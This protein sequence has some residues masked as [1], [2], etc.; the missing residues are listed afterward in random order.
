MKGFLKMDIVELKEAIIRKKAATA[1]I[2]KDIDDLDFLREEFLEKRNGTCK[3]VFPFIDPMLDRWGFLRERRIAMQKV[4]SIAFEYMKK[5]LKAG[6]YF[7][8]ITHKFIKN[9]YQLFDVSFNEKGEYVKKYF[10]APCDWARVIIEDISE[11]TK[12]KFAI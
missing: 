2:L 10:I 7:E 11:F 8:P 6:L 1:E 12:R 4:G 3:I 5:P 9:D